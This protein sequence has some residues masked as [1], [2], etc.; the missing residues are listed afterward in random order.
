METLSRDCECLVCQK[1]TKAYIHHLF[2]ARELLG[3]KLLTY[4][5][6]A[7]YADLMNKIRTSID[8]GSL[9][10]LKNEWLGK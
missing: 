5:N 6:L 10:V 4:H 8:D 1:Y 7:Y 9:Q 3:Y 2:K